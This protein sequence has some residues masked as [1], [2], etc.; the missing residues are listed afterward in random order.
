MCY[1]MTSQF[2]NLFQLG[3]FVKVEYRYPFLAITWLSCACV[4]KIPYL[5]RCIVLDALRVR[6][7]TLVILGHDYLYNES[8]LYVETPYEKTNFLKLNKFD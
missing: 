5:K 3:S 2:S 6:M 4:F 7:C 8:R 1:I